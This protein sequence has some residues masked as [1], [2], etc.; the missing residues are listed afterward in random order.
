MKRAFIPGVA[1]CFRRIQ[2]L[3]AKRRRFSDRAFEVARAVAIPLRVII[4]RWPCRFRKVPFD[5]Q[6]ERG[7]HPVPEHPAIERRT[8]QS[9]YKERSSCDS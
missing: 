2:G 3:P 4:M 8:Q 5:V 9:Q 6:L 1:G 7:F